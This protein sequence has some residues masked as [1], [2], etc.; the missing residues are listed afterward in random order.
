MLR[1]FN[2]LIIL[3]AAFPSD[4]ESLTIYPMLVE[5]K[6]ASN[7]RQHYSICHRQVLNIDEIK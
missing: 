7:G 2:V 1:A 5:I 6:F 4:A 3:S